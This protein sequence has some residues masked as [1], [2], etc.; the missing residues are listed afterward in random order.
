MSA[1]LSGQ[2]HLPVYGIINQEVVLR[3][4][5][6][7]TGSG[8]EMY[9]TFQSIILAHFSNNQMKIINEK[10][11]TRLEPSDSGTTLRIH[12]LTMEDAGI[13]AVS[14][15]TAGRKI[16]QTSYNLTVYEPVPSPYLRTEVMGYRTDGCNVTLQCSVPSHPS[17][18]S[19]TWKYRHQDQEY[20][21]YD[22]GST[23]QISL[24]PDHQDMEI[25]C[26]VHNP[27]DHKNV[28]STLQEICSDHANSPDIE[29]GIKRRYY[30]LIVLYVVVF[31]VI[32]SAGW[33]FMKRNKRRKAE[34]NRKEEPQEE[35]AYTKIKHPP[36]KNNDNKESTPR[37]NESEVR[38]QAK[39][40]T[41]DSRTV[42]DSALVE[43]YT[44]VRCYTPVDAT[45]IAGSL[46]SITDE[47]TNGSGL[48]DGRPRRELVLYSGIGSKGL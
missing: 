27:A 29:K 17:H 47:F 18:L 32:A 40:E 44:P 37:T 24:A 3:L 23:T 39:S 1:W 22:S 45:P 25:L 2:V 48:G 19:Y 11:M 34:E 43:G 13:Y 46:L 15:H 42:L 28:S 31:T 20:Q 7:Q 36:G 14:V 41:R 5:V 35:V 30:L 38:D 26:I 21:L 16:Y 6:D 33:Y 4:P 9:W 10:F 8:L 12:N